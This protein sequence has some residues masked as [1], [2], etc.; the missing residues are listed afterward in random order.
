MRGLEWD[1]GYWFGGIGV[2]TSAG[3]EGVG[4]EGEDVGGEAG[5]QE[6]G[7]VGWYSGGGRLGRSGHRSNFLVEDLYYSKRFS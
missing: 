5:L 1:P 4:T 3:F 2:R 7:F 6:G